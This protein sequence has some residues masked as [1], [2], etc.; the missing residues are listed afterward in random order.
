VKLKILGI[1]GSRA[2]YDLLSSLFKKLVS[3]D[4]FD[5][6]LLVSNAH[7]SP[8]FGMSVD[9][10][11]NDNIPILHKCESLIDADSHSS[12]LKTLS[13]NLISCVDIV[14]SYDPDL[15]L[16]AGDREDVI[17]GSLLSG[18][19]NIP[20]A[21]FYG[22]DH[23]DDGHV[24]NLVRNAASKMS[25][26]HFTSHTSHTE[27]LI[28]LGEEKRR[29]FQVGSI[30]LDKFRDFKAFSIDELSKKLGFNFDKEY[31]IVIYHPHPVHGEMEKDLSNFENIISELL[32]RKL[33]IF[34][35]SPNAD[36]G[37][38]KLVNHLNNYAKNSDIYMYKN[39]SRDL[40]LSL[41]VQAKILVGNSSAGISE[42]PSIPL[43]VVN[44]GMRQVGRLAPD[45]VLFSS[46]DKLDLS[47]KINSA[48]SDSFIKKISKLSNPYGDGNS[49]SR[50]LAILKNLDFQD[51]LLKSYDPLKND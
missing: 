25:S 18:Y 46:G 5:F 21:H 43:P 33:K 38:Q 37:N 15:L 20:S 32:K 2:D 47:E 24:D 44:V 45:N 23:V 48:L 7:M 34:I 29:V 14:S 3:D 26:I 9:L 10:I 50:I 19:L 1:T 27:R 31:A 17:I 36:P 13:V 49:V 39:L 51:F 16:Y 4:Y 12:R 40:F 22:G 8:R 11:L 28:K 6:K 35:S 42:A 30:S 41:F